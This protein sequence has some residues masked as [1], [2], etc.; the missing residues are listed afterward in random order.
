MQTWVWVILIVVALIVGIIGTIAIFKLIPGLKNKAADKEAKQILR[1]AQ[2]KSERIVKNS[3]ID[4]K[5]A[6]FEAKQNAQ[7]EIRQMKSEILTEQN[8]LDLREQTIDQR[9][10]ALLAKETSL[11]QKNEALNQRMAACDKKSGEL[12]E[13]INSILSELEKVSG[14]S[15]KEAHDEIMSRVESKMS[16]EIAAYI[17]NAEDDARDNAEAKARDLLS[18]A[19]DKYAQEVTTERTVAVIPLPSDELKGRIIGREG[20]NI[21]VLESTLGVDLVIDDTPEVITVS[22]FDPIRREVARRTLDTLVKDGRIQPGRIEE[23]A[24]KMKQQVTVET[25]KA[26]EDAAFKLG[27]PKINRELLGY[28]GRLKYRTSYGQ[29]ALDHSMEVAY[30]T[31]I[32][33]AE[34]GLDQ[35]L[36]RRAGLLHDIGKAIDF[37][38]EGSH[39]QLG[40]ELARKYNEPDVVINSIESHHGDVEATSVIAH[41]VAA[42]DTLSAARPGARS[43]TMETY[44]KRIGQLEEIAKGFDGVQ[45]AYAMQAGREVRVMV[46]PEKVSD[47]EAVKMAQEMREKIE[48]TMTYPGQIKVSVIREYRAVETAK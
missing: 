8:K 25:Q 18:L 7:N 31:G 28:L 47:A 44:V 16:S 35:N 36:A 3:E 6:A 17:K 19:C 33:A 2:I 4:A 15:V 34:L 20:R 21:R 45:Q 11:D 32:M 12:D 24:A 37:E 9:D 26:G 39:V 43:E 41:L 42:A 46:I 22:C 23:I 13:K 27:L 48:S 40:A 30:L 14:M 5:Q 1:D 38:Q 29:N 10:N